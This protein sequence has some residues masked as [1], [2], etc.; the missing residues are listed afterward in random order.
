MGWVGGWEATFLAVSFKFG[1]SGWVPSTIRLAHAKQLQARVRMS[2]EF[3]DFKA[4][5]RK[6][7]NPGV[8]RGR[9]GKRKKKKG[10]KPNFAGNS[11]KCGNCRQK[12]DSEGWVWS[13]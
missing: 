1:V 4:P 3:H 2:R 9:G 8:R 11:N 13:G 5:S 7:N 6:G 10:I 12:I